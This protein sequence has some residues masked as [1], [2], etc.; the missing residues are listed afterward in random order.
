MDQ[1]SNH[2]LEKAL[3]GEFL[4]AREGEHLFNTES[5]VRLMAAAHTV[6]QRLV[7]EMKLAGLL[8]EISISPI[9]VF[10]DAGFAISVG[11][12]AMPA[13]I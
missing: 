12:R 4:S 6:R 1:T 5:L 9:F 13:L 11:N 8:T 10:Q 3:A 7:P 2:L